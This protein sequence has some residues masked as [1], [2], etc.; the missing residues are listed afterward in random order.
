VCYVW[1]DYV[2]SAAPGALEA[3]DAEHQ[4]LKKRLEVLLK[5]KQDFR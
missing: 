5:C 1:L 4:A 2:W 3:L